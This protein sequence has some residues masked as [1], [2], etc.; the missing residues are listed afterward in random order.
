MFPFIEK[1]F[2]K[3]YSYF[4]ISIIFV[5]FGVIYCDFCKK[6]IFG[7]VISLMVI[8]KMFSFIEKVFQP[9]SG[10]LGLIFVIFEGN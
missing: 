1:W 4:P 10:N 2:S 9:S 7:D 8:R 6:L 5:E 3:I